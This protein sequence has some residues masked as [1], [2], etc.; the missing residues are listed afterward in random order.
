MTRDRFD[1]HSHSTASDGLLRPRELVALAAERGLGGIALT[2]HDTVAGIAEATGMGAA[3][4]I[5]V[6]AGVELSCI[7]T[8]GRLVHILGYGFDPADEGLEALFQQLRDERVRRAAAII[9]R[10]QAID[11]RL[12]VDAVSDEAGDAATGRP[13]IARAMVKLGMIDD[14]DAAFSA[15]WFGPHGPA[16]ESLRGIPLAT[17]IAAIH[18]AGGVA[19]YAHPGARTTDG[20]PESSIREAALAGLDGIEVDHPGH[21]GDAVQRCAELAIELGLI[22]TAGSDDHGVG[23]EGSR[24]GCRTVPARIVDAIDARVNARRVRS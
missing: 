20:V 3:L 24:L 5:R 4:G 12:S 16:W 6:V 18:S 9:E 17:G 15:T 14:V 1:L 11:G 8:T 2:D 22:Q 10:V 23:Q 21:D 7:D 19:V 13:H